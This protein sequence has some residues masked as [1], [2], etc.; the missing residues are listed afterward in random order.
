MMLILKVHRSGRNMRQVKKEKSY[1]MILRKL[2]NKSRVIPARE[3][4]PGWQKESSGRVPL[5]CKK[6]Q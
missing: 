1:K 5:W 3:M 2:L 4:M 6:V